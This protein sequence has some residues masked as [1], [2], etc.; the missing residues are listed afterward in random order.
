MLCEHS[1]SG[2][3]RAMIVDGSDS[4]YVRTVCEYAHL[5]AR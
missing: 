3:Y 2:R 1:F 5:K 4:A